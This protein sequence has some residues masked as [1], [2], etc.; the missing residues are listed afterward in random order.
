MMRLWIHEPAAKKGKGGRW[1]PSA[2]TDQSRPVVSKLCKKTKKKLLLQL[3]CLLQLQQKPQHRMLACTTAKYGMMYRRSGHSAFLSVCWMRCREGV[4]LSLIAHVDRFL[5][6]F[7][8]FISGLQTDIRG[9]V[10]SDGDSVVVMFVH[11]GQG[12]RR[13]YI[14]SRHGEQERKGKFTQGFGW[15]KTYLRA[16][17]ERRLGS[18]VSS[19][20]TGTR[21]R[22]Y[23]ATW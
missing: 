21:W 9:L 16:G 6:D 10:C 11:S 19:N 14:L 12:R 13:T 7:R 8:R 3:F 18:D 1:S 17:K 2:D 23:G 22:L 20:F 5:Y 4:C 15:W